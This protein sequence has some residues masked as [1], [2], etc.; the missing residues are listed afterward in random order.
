MKVPGSYIANLIRLPPDIEAVIRPDYPLLFRHPDS[1]L[2]YREQCTAL[3]APSRAQVR[4]PE[5]LPARFGVARL[6]MP[7]TIR[8]AA[9]M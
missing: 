9:L 4:Q 8:C 3:F 6:A 2:S 7:R 1:L 5:L